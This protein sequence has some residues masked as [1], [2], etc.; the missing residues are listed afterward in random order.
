MLLN[1]TLFAY[2]EN[3]LRCGSQLKL[4]KIG[5]RPNS[6]TYLNYFLFRIL[7]AWNALPRIIKYI[8]LTEYSKNTNFKRAV[9]EF[10]T[11]KLGDI[12]NDECYA[13]G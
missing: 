7:R 6:E 3:N 5:D 10:Y 2:K 12:F 13:L 8:E 1:I 11:E 9:K 4:C